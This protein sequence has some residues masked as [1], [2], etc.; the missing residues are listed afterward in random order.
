VKLSNDE[1]EDI[2][3]IAD[4]KKIDKSKFKFRCDFCKKSGFNEMSELVKHQDQVHVMP[5]IKSDTA[6][7]N[8]PVVNDEK[9]FFTHEKVVKIVDNV[10][11][12][13][14]IES[15][16][17]TCDDCGAGFNFFWRLE[18]HQVFVHLDMGDNPGFNHNNNVLCQLFSKSR[19]FNIFSKRF[20]FALHSA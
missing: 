4:R 14:V 16:K 10:V 8:V 13:T 2:I 18:M 7:K 17:Y 9:A 1:G 5:N 20:G 11:K 15:K 12:T 6:R 19:P 3:D